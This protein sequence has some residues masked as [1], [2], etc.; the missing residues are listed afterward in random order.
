MPRY[1][2]GPFSLDP[3]AR[4]LLRDGE[5]MPMAG[6]TLDTLVVLV[7]NRGR[8]VG[9]DEL[10]SRIWAGTIV[11]EA[12][13]SQTI[14]TVRKILGDTPKDHRYIATVPGR[15]YQFVA[16]V[17]EFTSET[18]QPAG[19]P[20]KAAADSV[21]NGN[22]ITRH[23]FVAVSVTAV[24][25]AA[26]GILWFLLRR[27]ARPSAEL[28]ERR[29]TFNS[30]ASP[31]A[32]AALSP[33]G[34]YLAYSDLTGIHLRLLSTGE[35]RQIP[36]PAGVPAAVSYVASWFPTGTELLAHSRDTGGHGSMWAVSIMG[37]SSREIRGDGWGWGLSPDGTRIAFSPSG[38]G[39]G[40][41]I[42]VMDS[43]GNNPHKVIGVPED[44]F[45][46]S[47][48]WSPDGHR[49]AYARAHRAGRLMES[50]DLNGANR[51]TV[52][53][54]EVRSLSWLPDRRIVYSKGEARD[55][56]ANL[57]QIGIDPVSGT[58]VG[59]PKRITR[60]A[61]SDLQGISASADGTRIVLKKESYP[62]QVYIGELATGVTPMSHP[63]RL[64]FDEAR[65]WA[66]AWTAD[67]K[68]VLFTSDRGGKW[69]VYKQQIRQATAE[70][71][72]EGR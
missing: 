28:V 16:P 1:T 48:C 33:D 50:C 23:K 3:E 46:W 4:V 70:P 68:A 32:S 62:S 56:D 19:A 21:K 12:N 34:K 22:P 29:L 17:T 6:K 39:F 67:S 9:K 26:V 2:F 27:P 51:T 38:A 31:V 53:V 24:L 18:L 45:L 58:P 11:E 47:V 59:T 42:W 5:P 20:Q 64:T 61:G 10:L 69:G 65:D 63:Q 57:W 41:E 14:F 52:V 8:L 37:R 55:V 72:T 66:T 15:G 36:S 30:S 49:L 43:Q 25:I 60:W 54:G 7:Q 13:L 35:E 44:E 40:R 71:L